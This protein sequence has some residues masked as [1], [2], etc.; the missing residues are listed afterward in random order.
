MCTT[1]TSILLSEPSQLQT[2]IVSSTNYNGYDISCNG[3]SDGGIDLTV[4][5]SVPGYT[6]SWN[7][8]LFTQDLDSL[9]SDMYVVNVTDANGCFINDS[10]FLQDPTPLVSAYTV[11]DI[12]GFNVCLMVLMA[13]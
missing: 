8:G 10:I 7:I 6:Y 9:S 13:Q 11:S 3:Y 1:S 5:G 2:S 4:I 12:N